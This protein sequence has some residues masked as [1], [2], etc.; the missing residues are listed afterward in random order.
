MHADVTVGISTK[1]RYDVLHL[2]LMGIA[3]QTVLPRELVIFDDGEQRDLRD[4]GVY[5]HVFKILDY[6]GI[7][8]GVFFGE[9]KGQVL[10]HQKVLE[11][12]KTEWIWRID[13]DNYPEPNVLENLLRVG[14]SN[15]TVGAVGS[16]VLHGDQIFSEKV[17][18][19][20][21]RDCL[22]KYAI[23]FARFNGV[24]QAEHLYSTFIYKKAAAKHGYPLDLSPVGHREETTFS[25]EMHK[26]G[27]KLMVCGDTITWHL[28]NPRGGIRSFHDFSYWAKDEEKFKG[29]L[30]SW[31]VTPN[32]YKFAVLNNGMGDHYVFKSILPEIREK[33]PKHKIFIGCC[34]PE[35]FSDEK[36]VEIGSIHDAGILTRGNVDQYDVYKFCGENKWDKHISEAFRKIYL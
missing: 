16:A 32:E 12:T 23:Q 21:I 30:A 1:D 22:T 2:C 5:K 33:Y 14:L 19:P 15:P 35:I 27:F 29:R 3:N 34:Y 31:G 26:K 7:K 25:Y 36:G 6:K 18:S 10:N 28:P 4:E 24:R 8:W 9:K 13:D 11:G 17:T 20:E